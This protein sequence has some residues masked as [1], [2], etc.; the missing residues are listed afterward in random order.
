LSDGV[1]SRFRFLPGADLIQRELPADCD[2]L[3]AV[4]CSDAERLGFPL[5][6]LPRRP[7]LNI[8][9]HPTN[10]RFA[11][12][13]LVSTSAA[14]TSE[15]LYDLMVEIDLP[16]DRDIAT[17]LL[18][19]IVTD[20]IG[21]RTENVSAHTLEVAARLLDYGPPLAD[22]YE[23]TLL[24]HTFP[25]MRYWGLALSKLNREEGLIWTAM[26]LE[27]RD[28]AGYVGDDDAD[29]INLLTTIDEALVTV[30]FIEQYE[31]RIKISWRARSGYDVSKLA[32]S[33]GG[34][35]HR[36]AAGAMV[37]GNLSDV[38]ERVLDATRR[39]LT[40]NVETGK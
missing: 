24:A 35:G 22:L 39:I 32:S 20:T 25:A 10:T 21:F 6:R 2:A 38:I 7:D 16:L 4:D 33:F 34:G 23:R 14:A 17:N 29:L 27:D 1:P 8:D 40:A 37:E 26:T 15:I 13:N 12:V 3:I 5:E 18:A 19:G 30:I 9:H 36:Q 11:E 31:G 28:H